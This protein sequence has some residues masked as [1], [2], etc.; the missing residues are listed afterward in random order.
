M[1]PGLER[2]DRYGHSVAIAHGLAVVGSPQDEPEN[3]HPTQNRGSASLYRANGDDGDLFESEAIKKFQA[4][5]AEDDDEFGS[6]VAI[7]KKKCFVVVIGAPQDDD[8]AVNAGAAYVFESMD[9]D[10]DVWSSTKK[11]LADDGRR[12][13]RFGTAVATD[14]HKI[15]VGAPNDDN[16]GSVYIF[17]K[18]GCDDDDDDKKG[19][20][21]D[22][23]WDWK[24]V[25]YSEKM[26]GWDGE[27]KKCMGKW[28]QVQKLTPTEPENRGRFGLSVAMSGCLI[29]VGAPHSNRALGTVYI[30]R[31]EW[32]AWKQL[33]KIEGPNFSRDDTHPP[34]PDLF[35]YDVALDWNLLIVGAPFF[36]DKNGIAYGYYH[37]DKDGD[38]WSDPVTIPSS[39]PPHPPPH[40]DHLYGWS[41]AVEKKHDF[42]FNT[43]NDPDFAALALVGAPTTRQNTDDRVYAFRSDDG[44]AMWTQ[45]LV[46]ADD[47]SPSNAIP[48]SDEFGYALAISKNVAIIGAPSYARRID[49]RNTGTAYIA[50]S[51]KD[52]P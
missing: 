7:G 51:F 22:D 17:M 48:A 24:K 5:D 36:G 34:P 6:S 14:G 12:N 33:K 3:G 26:K 21:W 10:G 8:N 40:P 42:N 31:K 16:E 1:E 52:A 37:K 28:V 30:F 25:D 38:V 13:D 35:G 18:K 50:S 47:T 32:W 49:P 19:K 2:A 23:D 46:F 20:D 27:K 41:V 45:E 43:G 39:S 29:A 9:K 11:L 4:D 44:G 15:L